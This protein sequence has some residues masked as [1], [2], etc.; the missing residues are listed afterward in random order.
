MFV[1]VDA[2]PDALLC[3]VWIEDDGA[4]IPANKRGELF[5]RGARL[6]T[7]KPGTGLGLAIVRDVVEIYGGSI[8]LAESEDLGGL[9]VALRLPR[10]NL[11]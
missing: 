4:G 9:L 5:T 7:E 2:E 11:R 1:T 8:D 3:V 10:A 6:D